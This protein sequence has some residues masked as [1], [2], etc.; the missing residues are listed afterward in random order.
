MEPGGP[1]SATETSGVGGGFEMR[2]SAQLR[3]RTGNRETSVDQLSDY[4]DLTDTKPL[5]LKGLPVLIGSRFYAAPSS[6]RSA[7]LHTLSARNLVLSVG[8]A[9]PERKV[10]M[11]EIAHQRGG[12]TMIACA[13]IRGRLS[14]TSTGKAMA[15][16]ASVVR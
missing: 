14:S 12:T 15:F 6:P 10:P 5:P 1:G 9:T 2:M 8:G 3:R 4:A 11:A 7:G 16:M 13:S